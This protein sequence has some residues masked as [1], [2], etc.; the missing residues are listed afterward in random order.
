M[1]LHAER[2]SPFNLPYSLHVQQLPV[3]EFDLLA[4]E[5]GPTV[6]GQ[7]HAS[8]NADACVECRSVENLNVMDFEYL[9]VWVDAEWT[10]VYQHLY[11]F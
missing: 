1:H 3:G 5:L 10:T 2:P 11:K 6:F 9:P 8:N 7:D 4:S